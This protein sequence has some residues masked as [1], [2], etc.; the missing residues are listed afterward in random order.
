[1]RF[2]L[3]I[4]FEGGKKMDL[5]YTEIYG[6]AD[7]KFIEEILER[8]LWIIEDGLK[9]IKTQKKV[10]SGIIDI[11]AQD[12]SNNYVVIE[13][14]PD[15]GNHNTVGQILSYMNALADELE[16]PRPSIRGVI[17]CRRKSDTIEVASRVVKG[18][19]FFEYDEI[20]EEKKD[21]MILSSLTKE[22]VYLIQNLRKKDWKSFE[23]WLKIIKHKQNLVEDS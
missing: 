10:K 15:L 23:D 21:K 22:V 5:L 19:E 12:K 20:V 6:V 7:E 8:N 13:I 4:K 1:M 11:L 9:L 18:L 17:F 16:I 14:K 2:K 3:S